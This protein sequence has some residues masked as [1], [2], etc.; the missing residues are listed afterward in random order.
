MLRVDF[1]NE[2]VKIVKKIYIN[3]WSPGEWLRCFS[4]CVGRFV[5]SRDRRPTYILLYRLL[6]C[7]LTTYESRVWRGELSERSERGVSHQ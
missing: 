3:N 5:S 1:C 4:F 6:I 2:S 7:L